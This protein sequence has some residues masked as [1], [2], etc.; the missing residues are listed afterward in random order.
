[1]VQSLSI[2]GRREDQSY[3]WP[4]DDVN[5]YEAVLVNSP[6]R[7]FNR[8]SRPDLLLSIC[9]P[10]LAGATL[11][12]TMLNCGKAIINP[13]I[14]S[15]LTNRASIYA[16]SRITDFT[17]L[18]NPTA[19]TQP[20]GVTESYWSLTMFNDADLMNDICKISDQE[21]Q[22]NTSVT[23]VILSLFSNQFLNL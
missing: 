3:R 1:M 11:V 10:T 17:S 21:V 14:F 6:I 18:V 20:P 7:N 8:E 5:Y 4:C 15:N 13:A 16:S 2:D 23:N 12:S 19:V 22:D 9:L